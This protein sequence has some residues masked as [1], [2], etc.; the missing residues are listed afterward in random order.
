MQLSQCSDQLLWPK[1]KLVLI[2]TGSKP[3]KNFIR[4]IES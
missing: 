3:F 2:E 4:F 1:Y